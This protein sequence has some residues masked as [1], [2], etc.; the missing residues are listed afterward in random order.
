MKQNET[1]RSLWV[2]TAGMLINARR[3]GMTLL[4]TLLL[5]MT[6][7]TAGA[8]GV[9][10]I[11]AAGVT[12]N[13]ATDDI[14]GNDNPAAMTNSN[15]NIGTAGQAT[16]YVVNS[17]VTFSNRL[18]LEGDVHLILADGGEL[19]VTPYIYIDTNSSLTIYS[20]STGASKGKLTVS[21][22]VDECINVNGSLTING[23]DISLTSTTGCGFMIGTGVSAIINNGQVSVS[24]GKYGVYND[25]GYLTIN[26]GDVMI[27]GG[28]NNHNYNAISAMSNYTEN[29]GNVVLNDK[30][31][32]QTVC[33]YV[34]AAGTAKSHYAGALTNTSSTI[35]YQ[36]G[37]TWFIVNEDV[38]F[39]RF[40]YIYGHVNLILADGKKLTVNSSD[41]GFYFTD[42]S[43]LTI[44]SQSHDDGKGQLSVTTSTGFSIPHQSLTINGGNIS[45]E[46]SGY[47]VYI[48]DGSMTVNNGDV[49]IK[50]NNDVAINKLS[51]YHYTGGSVTL[52]DYFAT[53][54][55]TSYV[56]A[57]GVVQSSVQA[58]VVASSN[59]G[60]I[61]QTTWY[62]VKDD[63]TFTRN[64]TILGTVNLIL[65]DGKELTVNSSDTDYGIYLGD[66]SSLNIYT[67]SHGTSK[68]KLTVSSG[69]SGIEVGNNNL[70]INGG[71][72]SIT[73]RG[74]TIPG[75][76]IG[77]SGSMTLNNGDV[78]VTGR[79]GVA[80]DDRSKFTQNGGLLNG[81]DGVVESESTNY[82]DAAGTSQS[83]TATILKSGMPS[84]GTAGQATWYVAKGTVNFPNKFRF[85]GHVNLILA[86]GAVMT[87]NATNDDGI[88]IY[89]NSSLTIYSQST[90]SSKG[91]LIAQSEFDDG[92][93]I[94]AST[95]SLTINGGEVTAKGK[96]GANGIW[97]R[98]GNMTVNGGQV[99]VT[100]LGGNPGGITFQDGGTLTLGYHSPD[101]FVKIDAIVNAN[102]TLG[103]V[104][105][106]SGQHFVADD[107]DAIVTGNG[108]AYTAV[109]GKKLVPCYA[110]TFDAGSG[111]FSSESTILL[112]AKFDTSGNAYVSAPATDP[113]RSGYS[114]GGWYNG[115][116]Q[117]NCTAAVTGDLTLTAHWTENIA[118]LTEANPITPLTAMS[119]K[120]TKVNFTRSGLTAGKYSTICLPFDFTASET[121]TFYK[122][123][124]VKKVGDD[125]V[126]DISATTGGTANTPYIFTTDATSVTFSNDAVTATDSYS[127]A[128]AKTSITDWTFQGTY[129]QISLPN[130]SGEYDYGFAAGSNSDGV[131][132][133]DF[134]HL[135][136]GASAA[137]FR[138]YL[139]YTGS[140]V[141]WAKTRGDGD[142]LPSR[143]IVRI[144]KANGDATVIGTL[145]TRTGEISTGDWYSIDGHRLQGKPAKKGLYI[146]NGRK[147]VIK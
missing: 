40:L 9:D 65:A 35:G 24:G 83:K 4:A 49:T 60:S 70:T 145:D 41:Y 26:G 136:S 129:A 89:E 84:I 146:N 46:T 33:S 72:I 6:A 135:V 118:K 5:S 61:G 11:D 120:Q 16:W 31:V 62:V 143:I 28:T 68:G 94:N 74:T 79:N 105:I 29:G 93:S 131:N 53:N 126:A 115:S 19:E 132:I 18:G 3:A 64:V 12:K 86:D 63:I 48:E 124:G 125:W 52:Y 51:N 32:I 80:I 66:N 122:F 119:G 139:K 113:T 117:Y 37:N 36:G 110:V 108:V 38:T 23:G 73:S 99:T 142:A 103:T 10:Y 134:V 140:D 56:D 100:N 76:S 14:A 20:Q 58:T 85:T 45:V 39:D 87:V 59:I 95:S 2:L 137:P 1:I 127:D 82:L 121:C 96:A 144:V 25:N 104:N 107:G 44:Y 21:S 55:L 47:G 75:I 92:I 42:N 102:E 106:K 34:D 114:F 43:S 8:D 112:P 123:D 77:G 88:Y 7:Q 30:G 133:G 78:T 91:K 147:V 109:A 27:T 71:L 54:P 116:D 90:G 15:N 57:A 17:K 130:V 111:S 101:D 98:A 13:T 128:T 97:I 141:N 50:S 69:Y 67:Q 81:F 22:N 138:A